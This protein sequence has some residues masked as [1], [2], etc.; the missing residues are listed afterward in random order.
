MLRNRQKV[1]VLFIIRETYK[2][3]SREK[4][5]N[6]GVKMLS[7]HLHCDFCIFDP[8]D[9]TKFIPTIPPIPQT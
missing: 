6:F 7:R 8:T 4:D 9:E 1:F 2:L 5:E 3:K